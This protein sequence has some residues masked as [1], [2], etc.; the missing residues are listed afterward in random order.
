MALALLGVALLIYGDN[1]GR[2]WLGYMGLA[3]ILAAFL[4]R[5]VQKRFAPQRK[6][7]A[8]PS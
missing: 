6:D 2:P 4:L 1:T 5:F 8:T 7:P 3:P